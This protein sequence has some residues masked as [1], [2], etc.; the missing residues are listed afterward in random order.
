MK[1]SPKS[2][3]ASPSPKQEPSSPPSEPLDNDLTPPSKKRSRNPKTPASP[4]K[5]TALTSTQQANTKAMAWDADGREALIQ[6]LI[7]EGLKVS[8]K[9]KLAEQVS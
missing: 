4:S 5:K 2:P 3:L 7:A 8:D 6:H 9:A 1:R